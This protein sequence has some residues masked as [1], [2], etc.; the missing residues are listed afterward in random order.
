MFSDAVT[1]TWEDRL[2]TTDLDMILIS[3][4]I[5]IFK[6]NCGANGLYQN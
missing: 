6:E 1:L 3:S 5:F 4:I 2:D